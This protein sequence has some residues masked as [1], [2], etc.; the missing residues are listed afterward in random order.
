MF[1]RITAVLWA[2]VLSLV[3]LWSGTLPVLAQ[4]IPSLQ[5]NIPTQTYQIQTDIG[6][7]N[8]DVL[9]FSNLS[10]NQF[11]PTP[12]DQAFLGQLE[13][14]NPGANLSHLLP[15]TD[16]N[17][18]QYL[19]IGSIAGGEAFGVGQMSLEQIANTSGVNIANTKLGELGDIVRQQTPAVLLQ[20]LPQLAN[21]D[22][23]Q[24]KPIR[25]LAIQYFNAGG[26]LGNGL[27]GIQNFDTAAKAL[28]RG[29]KEGWYGQ[30]RPIADCCRN[31]PNYTCA[32]QQ[33]NDHDAIDRVGGHVQKYQRAIEQARKAQPVATKPGDKD[34]PTPQ[35]AN[36]CG[37]GVP[38]TGSANERI[39]K[40]AQELKGRIP[41]CDRAETDYGRNGCAVAVDTVLQ[42]AGVP[43]FGGSRP[44]LSIT[45][46]IDECQ[47]GRKGTLISPSQAQAGD[48]LIMDDGVAKGHIG[49]C[50][51]A[52]CNTTLSN[53]SSRCN[54]VWESD[55]CFTGG[56]GCTAQF[57]RYICRVKA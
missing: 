41:Q 52:G 48:I 10:F 33:V 25:D 30:G 22:L 56:Y 5:S 7:Q 19:P 50:T 35:A 46:A 20:D 18:T 51:S 34:E 40:K 12:I 24:V 6:P 32:C 44:A 9:N 55:G 2:I 28:C 11:P 57:K 1:N 53:S 42:A 37:G 43:M 54:F 26:K 13:Q 31:G 45:S 15:G 39:A 3:Y 23:D 29:L 47:S 4:A 17:P 49:I 16:A 21:L 38:A 14:I 36:P 27:E 8:V